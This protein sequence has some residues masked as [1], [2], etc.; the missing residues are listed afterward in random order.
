MSWPKQEKV[1]LSRALREGA[2]L[3]LNVHRAPRF[4]ASFAIVR[5]RCVLRCAHESLEEAGVLVARPHR[6]GDRRETQ[7]LEAARR[8]DDPNLPKH[9]GEAGR[10]LAPLGSHARRARSRP[11]GQPPLPL[12]LLLGVMVNRR[13]VIAL[14]AA[15]GAVAPFA[16]IGA[17]ARGDETTPRP[18]VT[19][20]DNA[21]VM[22][23][24]PPAVQAAMKRGGDGHVYVTW[25]DMS[26]STSR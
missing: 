17:G 10:Q 9:R 20:D 18:V 21:L 6:P 24:A 13:N 7:R 14:I 11:Q 15:I 16:A 5:L 25:G 1:T 8:P 19:P 2:Q 3:Y 26:P 23:F 22:P 12:T 4:C